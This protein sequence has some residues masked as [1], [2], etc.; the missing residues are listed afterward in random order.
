[1]MKNPKQKQHYVL[2]TIQTNIQRLPVKLY[3]LLFWG[4]MKCRENSDMIL[5]KITQHK[6]I[7]GYKHTTNSIYFLISA[8]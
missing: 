5:E 2:Q 1:M 4:K 7:L 8:L 3:V 6:E